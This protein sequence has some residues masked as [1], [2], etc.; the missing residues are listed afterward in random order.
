MVC[1]E[2]GV[3][4]RVKPRRAQWVR[5]RDA[6]HSCGAGCAA[7][8]AAV[9]NYV[10]HGEPC[11]PCGC[12][13]NARRMW[14]KLPVATRLE[15]RTKESNADASGRVDTL[16]RNESNRYDFAVSAGRLPRGLS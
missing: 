8:V 12:A 13:A 2:G 1:A 7:C 16:A 14:A 10:E 6:A 5:L 4:G 9:C 11:V 15:T 3:C